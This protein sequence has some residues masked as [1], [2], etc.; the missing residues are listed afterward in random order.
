V[1]APVRP[2][3]IH[4]DCIETMRRLVAEGVQFDAFVGDPP[5]HLE[6]IVRRFGS[7]DAAPAQIG[8]TGAFSRASTGFMGQ[9]WDG[10]TADGK[11]IAFEVETWELVY[12]L[13]KPGAFLLAFGAT[14]TYHRLACAIEDAGFEIRD[15]VAWAYAS[16]FP[17]SRD[18][19]ADIDKELGH[20]RPK[21]GESRS[22]PAMNMGG[23][24]ARD[25]H[26]R[27]AEDGGKFDRTEPVSDEARLYDDFRTT[28]KPALEPICMAR[29]PLAEGSV[30]RNV[31]AYGTGGLNI[32]A[33]RVPFASEADEAESK[34]KNRH[35]QFESGPR[36]NHIFKPDERH[37]GDYDANGRWPANLVHDGSA[38]VLA[39]FPTTLPA[40]AGKP[41]TGEAGVGWTMTAT[42][43]EYDDAGGSAARFFF[44]AKADTSDR[45]NRCK[46]C[47]ARTIGAPPTCHRDEETGKPL[48]TRH[49]TV[50]PLELMRWAVRLVTPPGGLVLD[51]FAGTGSTG[52]AADREGMRSVLIEQSADFVGDIEYRLA[53][54]AG[55]D[56]PLFGAA[57]GA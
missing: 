50:K 16:G 27:Q 29:K 19:S 35:G 4:G 18:I 34:L 28:L 40:R 17:K 43:S 6:S 31:L 57:N 15:M 54:L 30:A 25:W 38:E 8:A 49:P 13:L 39:C 21:V 56:T 55:G 23:E 7:E 1:V 24:N 2:E 14:K 12:Q 45:V 53:A 41:R 37:R 42:G 51:C 46:K 11:R 10:R 47:G 26:Q 9:K 32:G 36:D 44:S 20:E 48:V 33:C 3:I 22:G 52:I 5:Y